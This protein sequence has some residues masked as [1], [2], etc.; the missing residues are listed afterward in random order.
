MNGSAVRSHGRP[1]RGAAAAGRH[2]CRGRHAL[3]LAL[4]CCWLRRWPWACWAWR[5]QRGLELG[6]GRGLGPDPRHPRA[7]HAGRT[8]C[9]CAAGP[10]RCLAQGLFRNPLAD[11]YLLGSA[12]GAGLGVVLVLA[13]GGLLGVSLGRRADRALLRLGL[14]GA[15]FV[16]ALG[17]VA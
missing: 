10:G 2:R 3:A 5:R 17:G 14:V 11:P 7:A 15:A 4:A 16:G 9:R 13:A 12:A 8:G 1:G 6:L